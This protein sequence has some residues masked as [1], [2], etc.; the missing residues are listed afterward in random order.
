MQLLKGFILV[1]SHKN[2]QYRKSFLNCKLIYVPSTSTQVY[3]LT[4]HPV[5]GNVWKLGIRQGNKILNE[6]KNASNSQEK[7][8]SEQKLK[9]HR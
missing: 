9:D 5:Y 6:K 7:Q 8:T 1:N 3:L 4:V 2:A